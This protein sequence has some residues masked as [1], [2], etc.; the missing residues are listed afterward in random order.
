MAALTGEYPKAIPRSAWLAARASNA[1]QRPI[2]IGAVGIA[3]FVAALVALVLAPREVRRSR[4]AIL[5]IGARPDTTLL[6]S[7]ERRAQQRLVAA[8]SSLALA[9]AR[10][11]PAPAVVD[12]VNPV[13][14]QRRDSLV[15]ALND[16]SSLLDRA[17]TAP[18]TASYRVLA[19][20]PQLSSNP[21][22]HALLDSLSEID[23]DR[24]GFGD[25]GGADP[26]FVALT[27]HA[28]EVGRA[29][30]AV[31]EERRDA[32]RRDIAGISAPKPTQQRSIAVVPPADTGS[33]LAERDSARSMFELARSELADVREK[34][35]D[36]DRELTRARSESTA[37]PP[38]IAMLAS[39]LTLGIVL[40]F[41]S[42][43]VGEFKRPRVSN[44]HEVERLT[45]A[46]VLATL[47][48]RPPN[49]ERG[50]RLADKEA[51]PYFDPGA[52]GYQLT[53]LHVART[54]ASRLMLTIAAQETAI[55]AVVAVNVAAIAADE[56][57]TTVV[58]DTDG[59]S[60]PVAAAL[61]IQAEP[62]VADILDSATEWAEAT[63]QATI[64]RD[65]VIDVIPSGV[66]S[67]GRRLTAITELF[68]QEIGRL[69]RHYEA[70]IIVASTEQAAAGLPGALPITD[71]I[72]C[73]RVGHTP[74]AALQA[75]LDNVH[76]AGGN[77]VGVVL[78]SGD[79]PAFPTPETLAGASRALQTREMKAITVSR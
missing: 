76:S 43:L 50:R 12:S 25:S 38:G 63:T 70:I 54:G 66:A 11:T 22:V 61:K 14:N 23:R 33:W 64:G 75:A 17:Q 19:E 39:A 29:I 6:V 52:D 21:R 24:A 57:R 10:P 74:L 49:P 58:V 2:F 78:W 32:L 36:Y 59:R 34:A 62:G 65:R 26:V 69:S 45:G 68:R 37:S 5:A 35:A 51:P 13:T 28:T 55:A 60:A 56:A 1:M 15:R 16:L 31:G 40:G 46:R 18:L 41:G 71:T 20:S 27:S 9:R 8:E 73:A 44:E 3:T 47:R 77:P 7:A 72:V 4:P 42:A 48:P 67:N 53:Y 79:P 30:Q